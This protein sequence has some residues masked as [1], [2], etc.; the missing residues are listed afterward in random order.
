MNISEATDASPLLFIG[1]RAYIWVEAFGMWQD[2]V[3]DGNVWRVADGDTVENK[4]VSKWV[5]L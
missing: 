2:G 4:Y 3:W 1:M 5:I